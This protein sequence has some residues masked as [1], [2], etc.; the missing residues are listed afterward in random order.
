VTKENARRSTTI[1]QANE[2]PS[3]INS[4][5]SG[6]IT[7]KEL[8]TIAFSSS[9]DTTPVVTISSK[10]RQDMLVNP[11]PI[12]R[13]KGRAKAIDVA[14]YLVYLAVCEDEPDFLS[15]LR[16]QKLLYYVQGWSLGIRNKTMFDDR[17]EAWAHGPVVRNIYYVF[18]DY[19][20]KP[21]LL[22]DVGAAENLT[23]EDMGFIQSVWSSYKQFSASSLREMTHKDAPWRDARGDCGPSDR[24]ENEI[25]IKAMK[26]FFSSQASKT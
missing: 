24:C 10:F 4:F 26:D 17:I 3:T 7:D 21:V 11:V 18:A 16:L 1:S 6:Q 22:E 23:E 20:Y 13:T 8:S 2:N 15:H 25:T 12:K 9:Y 5:V 19:G 14:K